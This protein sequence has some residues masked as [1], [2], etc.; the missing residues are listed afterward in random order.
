MESDCPQ[1]HQWATSILFSFAYLLSQKNQAIKSLLHDTWPQQDIPTALVTSGCPTDFLT[2]MLDSA[3][4]CYG[5]FPR[6]SLFSCLCSLLSSFPFRTRP[7][8]GG[9]IY[10]HPRSPLFLSCTLSP[11]CLYS[12]SPSALCFLSGVGYANWLSL[13]SPHALLTQVDSFISSRQFSYTAS[14]FPHDSSCSTTF[15]SILCWCVP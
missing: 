1:S 6:Q 7:I 15:Y 14:M 8:H 3:H 12:C 4:I 9:P 5:Q 2:Q 11:G 13:C 10:V